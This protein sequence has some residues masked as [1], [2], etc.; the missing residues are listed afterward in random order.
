MGFE[1]SVEY[2]FGVYVCDSVDDL[3]D[4]N[5]DAFFIGFVLFAGDEFLEVLL[6]V[7]EDDL[8][9]LFFG[10]VEDLE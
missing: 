1:V 8:E 4:D 2:A 3:L 6:I 9:G 7:V 10:F 5:F